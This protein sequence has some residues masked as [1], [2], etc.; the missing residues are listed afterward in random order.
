VNDLTSNKQ[1]S[2]RETAMKQIVVFAN[3]VLIG[4]AVL[5]MVVRRGDR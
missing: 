1:G 2:V 3:L 4:F 5:F